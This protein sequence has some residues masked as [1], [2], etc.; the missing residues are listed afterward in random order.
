MHRNMVWYSCGPS[1]RNISVYLPPYM[2][3]P[4]LNRWVSLPESSPDLIVPL[5]Q[6]KCEQTWK[7]LDLFGTWMQHDW[8]YKREKVG[9]WRQW[10]EIA[11]LTCGKKKEDNKC[12]IKNRWRKSHGGKDVGGKK[13]EGWIEYKKSDVH[14]CVCLWGRINMN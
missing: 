10:C 6:P 14:V 2:C 1:M 3:L 4:A 13:I 9:R 8:K 11:A 12:V 7:N 5:L